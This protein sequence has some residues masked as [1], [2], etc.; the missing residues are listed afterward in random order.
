M[1]FNVLLWKQGPSEPLTENP[2]NSKIYYYTT[3]S[4]SLYVMIL[5]SAT[6]VQLPVLSA[7]RKEQKYYSSKY[8]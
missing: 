3:S 4:S 7:Q 1:I 5:I 6:P 2:Q 8:L